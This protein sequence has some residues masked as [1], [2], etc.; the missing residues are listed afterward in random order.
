MQSYQGHKEQL[1]GD[2]LL[3][4]T[5]AI[6]GKCNKQREALNTGETRVGTFFV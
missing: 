3:E 6:Q 2:A 5:M 4:Q 1:F